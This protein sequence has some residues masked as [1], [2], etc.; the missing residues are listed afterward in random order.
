MKDEAAQMKASEVTKNH[1]N[2]L[3]PNR[4][5]NKRGAAARAHARDFTHKFIINFENVRQSPTL[6]P[7]R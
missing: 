1:T 4:R 7:N 5:G 6:P 2:L 3:S